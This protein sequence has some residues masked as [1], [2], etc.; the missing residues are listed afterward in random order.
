[1]P[2]EMM[3]GMNT[4]A[5]NPGMA[6]DGAGVIPE[7]QM[8]PPQPK[9]IRE[10]LDLV[11]AAGQTPTFT[12][13]PGQTGQFSQ[14]G[15]AMVFQ[16]IGR[17]GEIIPPGQT[18]PAIPEE[19][20]DPADRRVSGSDPYDMAIE[21]LND[22]LPGMWKEM[23][24][25]VE[26]NAQISQ[27]QM[28]KW[29]GFVN[30]ATNNLVKHYETK[31]GKTRDSGEKLIKAH[32]SGPSVDKFLRSGRFEDLEK[33]IDY[34]SIA[35]KAAADYEKLGEYDEAKDMGVDE[36]IKKRI[37]AVQRALQDVV[38]SKEKGGKELSIPQELQGQA[39][40][41]K[42]LYQDLIS[43]G[44]PPEKVREMVSLKFPQLVPYL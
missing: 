3:P 39:E 20:G 5:R 38:A 18:P 8:M 11:R 26:S 6:P 37:D 13:V 35:S 1:M 12:N 15:G 7:Q 14:E 25:G 40:Q 29:Q 24:P 27:E 36:F 32:F 30:H 22:M 16:D 2:N 19:A 41:A 34:E 4:Q 17:G 9:T 10:Y 33:E 28:G 31:I 21:R 23:F 42:K 44:A 43:Q